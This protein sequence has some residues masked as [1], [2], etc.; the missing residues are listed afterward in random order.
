MEIVRVNIKVVQ[1][2]SG[3]FIEIPVLLYKNKQPVK[4]L[5]DFFLE[6]K[7]YGMSISTIYY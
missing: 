3:V 1:D 7:H 2:Y 5:F 6:H 4:P